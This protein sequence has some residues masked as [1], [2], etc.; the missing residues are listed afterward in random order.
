[1]E[2]RNRYEKEKKLIRRQQSES[3][4]RHS[5][6]HEQGREDREIRYRILTTGLCV[7]CEFLKVWTERINGDERVVIGCAQN[8]SPFLLHLNTPLGQKPECSEFS[9]FEEDP[10][11]R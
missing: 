1:M 8:K 10:N 5:R 6:D 7:D 3:T 2:R 9:P 11:V 4:K